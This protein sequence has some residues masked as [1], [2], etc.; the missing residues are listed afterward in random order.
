MEHSHMDMDMC[1]HPRPSKAMIMLMMYTAWGCT[2]T[3]WS[4]ALTTARSTHGT[5]HTD[6]HE[7]AITRSQ[8]M[9]VGCHA[10][11]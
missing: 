7:H 1:A 11:R 8:A 2:A 5:W 10:W 4:A 9:P 6:T 3:S